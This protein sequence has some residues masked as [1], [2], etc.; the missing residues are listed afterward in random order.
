MHD[1]VSA[2][3]GAEL[4]DKRVKSLANGTTGS[5]QAATLAVSAIGRALALSQGLD[6]KHA[7]KQVDRLLSNAGI[8]V[9]KAQAL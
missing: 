5:M 7:I 8:D 1:V 6:P 4:H 3:F 9:E 2:V